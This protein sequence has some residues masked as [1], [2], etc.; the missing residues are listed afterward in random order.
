MQ[1]VHRSRRQGRN[2]RARRDDLRVS[3]EPAA[4]PEGRGLGACAGAVALVA[5][6]CRRTV[7]QGSGYRRL[8]PGAD[9][10]LRNSPGHGHSDFGQRARPQRRCGVHQVPGVHG[11]GSRPGDPRSTRQCRVRRQLHQF[12]LV[13]F[14]R[15]CPCPQGTQDSQGRDHA[16]RAGLAADQEGRRSRG[17]A[18]YLHRGG[19]RVARVGLLH[20]PG[21]ERRPGPE[22][23]IF[24]QHQQP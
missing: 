5:D 3:R 24:R 21:D 13:G 19:R 8:D 20:V 9:D 18:P 17:P 10:H 2:D 12:A 1:H 15:R 14:A 6:R 11:T 4:C 7:R 22:G 23:A 16:G